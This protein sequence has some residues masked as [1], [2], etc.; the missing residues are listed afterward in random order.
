[1]ARPRAASGSYR[2]SVR[3]RKGRGLLGDE[4]DRRG[5]VLTDTRPPSVGRVGVGEGKMK[6]ARL[7][8]ERWKGS[9]SLASSF[10]HLRLTRGSQR[11]EPYRSMHVKGRTAVARSQGAC[12]LGLEGRAAAG[13]AGPRLAGLLGLARVSGPPHS[14]AKQ[15]GSSRELGRPAAARMG[16]QR[17]ARAGSSWTK[18]DGEAS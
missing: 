9:A 5:R 7:I 15:L 6:M 11:R 10:L 1:M 3:V 18:E 14:W 16:Q 17:R 4:G 8:V 2:R 13:Q 12:A